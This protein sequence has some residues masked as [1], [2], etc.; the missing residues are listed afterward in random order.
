[1]EKNRP[2][3]WLLTCPDCKKTREVSNSGKCVAVK[4][5]DT[6]CRSCAYKHAKSAKRYNTKLIRFIKR[7]EKGWL[8]EC[9]E[10]Q[11]QFEITRGHVSYK[12]KVGHTRC[13]SCSTKGKRHWRFNEFAS[14][15]RIY[16]R[17]EWS[18]VRRV[19]RKRD[20]VCQFPSCQRKRSSDGKSLSVHHIEPLRINRKHDLHNLIALCSEHHT[21]S[22]QHLDESIPLLKNIM[23]RK[24]A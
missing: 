9:P 22:D 21:W 11:R 3:F 23:A 10:C 24:L 4:S 20:K 5:G 17:A 15:K 14:R 2:W 1:M 7:T 12:V 19:V 18:R 8:I 16:Q 6:R 13:R